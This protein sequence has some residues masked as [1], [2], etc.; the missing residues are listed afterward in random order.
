MF[1]DNMHVLLHSILRFLC[2]NYIF[3]CMRAPYTEKNIDYFDSKTLLKTMHLKIV[4]NKIT[5]IYMGKF[6]YFE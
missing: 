2:H 6:T 4:A 5:E 1:V 3:T